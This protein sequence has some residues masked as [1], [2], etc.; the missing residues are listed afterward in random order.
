[1]LYLVVYPGIES[2][3]RG[4][5][6]IDYKRIEYLR[7]YTQVRYLLHVSIS[8]ITFK[9]LKDTHCSVQEQEVKIEQIQ[10]DTQDHRQEIKATVTEIYCIKTN[11]ELHEDRLER[12]ERIVRNQEKSL[13]SQEKKLEEVKEENKKRGEELQAQ[14]KRVDGWNLASL[15]EPF[16][17]STGATWPLPPGILSTA[18][19]EPSSIPT[20][21]LGIPAVQPAHRTRGLEKEETLEKTSKGLKD[22]SASRTLV[23]GG[24]GE[25]A[26]RS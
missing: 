14:D 21:R 5:T 25:A 6:K 12:L 24:P 3:A 16:V 9:W 20:R 4:S 19:P 2:V 7:V 26:R 22:P 10:Q 18:R 23:Q 1:M 8:I 11:Y 15:R 13:I 17:Q